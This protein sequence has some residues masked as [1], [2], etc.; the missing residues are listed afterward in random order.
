MQERDETISSGSSTDTTKKTGSDKYN[1]DMELILPMFESNAD[2]MKRAL[3]IEDVY[4]LAIA[5]L[6]VL[7]MG[8][9]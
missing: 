1:R 8:V 7:F 3:E 5:E 2:I 6:D 4:M 9:L